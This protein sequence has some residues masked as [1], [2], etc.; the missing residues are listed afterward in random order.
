MFLSILKLSPLPCPSLPECN[1]GRP[2]CKV[3]I[4]TDSFAGSSPRD[5]GSEA[6]VTSKAVVALL[7]ALSQ[8]SSR[9][10]SMT[11]RRF[12][13]SAWSRTK[14]PKPD[15]GRACISVKLL[16]RDSENCASITSG[17]CGSCH[18]AKAG[19]SA[20]VGDHGFGY[21]HVPFASPLCCLSCRPC[22]SRF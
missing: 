16:A 7:S 9:T 13:S 18:I 2:L 19:K 5:S 3:K 22:F 4:S 11:V 20:H 15:R 10:S 1:R 12:S 8:G 14:W 21:S 6:T 17:K